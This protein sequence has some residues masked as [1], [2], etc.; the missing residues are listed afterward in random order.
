MTI[1]RF[2]AQRENG[3]PAEADSPRVSIL[4]GLLAMREEM[5]FNMPLRNIHAPFEVKM[6]EKAHGYCVEHLQTAS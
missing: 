2:N 6:L 1:F 3:N 5:V 4:P